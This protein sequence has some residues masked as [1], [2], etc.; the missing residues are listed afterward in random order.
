[1][2]TKQIDMLLQKRESERLEFKATAD[3][4]AAVAATVCA[5]LNGKGGTVV[6]GVN[7]QGQVQPFPDADERV[8]EIESKL[9]AKISPASLWSV[10]AAISTRG[11]VIVIDVPA[12]SDRPYVCGGSIFV[13]KGSHT[14][15][16]DSVVIRHLV[17]QEHGEPTLW[18]NLPAA[19]LDLEELDS[20]IIYRTV[21]EAQRD[22][23]YTFR[24]PDDRAAIL[25][26]LS[27]SQSG[28]LTNGADVLFGKNPCGRLPQTRVR[29]TVYSTDKGGDFVDDRQ[30]EGNA[31]A[32]LEQVFS[33]VQQHVRVASVFEPGK[34][35][36]QDR[37]QY[38]FSALR[39]GVV[40]AII[41]RD[42]SVYS[43]G[44]AVGVYP[45]RIEI[46]N[47]GRLPKGWKLGD[48]KKAH[49]SQPANPRMAHVFYL[50]GIIERVG[51]GTLKILDDCKAAG[52]RTPQWKE[53]ASGITLVFHGK[54]QR[55][56]LNRRQRDLLK[57]LQPGAELRPGEY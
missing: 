23:S 3:D 17:A 56:R 26:D 13:R 15:A 6:L 1:V 32:L 2:N 37:P 51:R 53:A 19:S 49:P 42:Y 5:M 7:D 47:T 52:L 24:H 27:L 21:E 9:Y 36:R 8:R 28:I 20:E 48:L 54:P 45:D 31:F 14:V 43:G 38:P 50:R 18:E 29:A 34:L 11:K 30:F 39:E 40:N 41:H 25:S 46:W 16:A 4:V 57:R 22:R 55:A 12:G 35:D 10:N 33:F 44:M